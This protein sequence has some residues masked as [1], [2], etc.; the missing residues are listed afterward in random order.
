IVLKSK[1]DFEYSKKNYSFVKFNRVKTNGNIVKDII[2]LDKNNI[3]DKPSEELIFFYEK[4]KIQIF[5]DLTPSMKRTS[6]MDSE[7]YKKSRG[8][9]DV[10][11][12]SK[13]FTLY[14]KRKELFKKYLDN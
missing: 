7:L 12:I 6:I 8:V 4:M 10:L 2:R 11:N 9:Y 3:V 14:K 13:L 1:L 5:S